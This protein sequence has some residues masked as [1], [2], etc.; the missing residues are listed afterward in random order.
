MAKSKVFT[1]LYWIMIINN[2]DNN[3]NDDD[4]DT[5]TNDDDNNNKIIVIMMMMIMMMIIT[6]TTTIIIIQR[7]HRFWVCRDN[8]G[9]G[10]MMFKG[11]RPV[12]EGFVVSMHEGVCE[13][14]SQI[15]RAL[16]R[17]IWCTV[18]TS[19]SALGQQ[20]PTDLINHDYNMTF[21]ISPREC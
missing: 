10:L 20:T 12:L 7:F 4:D 15:P 2:N 8:L 3:N 13:T 16:A 18:R 14:G 11:L 1:Y 9:I 6:I 21:S 5:A 19:L 17:G